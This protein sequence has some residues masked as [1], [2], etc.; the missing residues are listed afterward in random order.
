M[1]IPY[2][3]WSGYEVALD[4]HPVLTK[5]LINVVIY[6]VGDYM[7][8]VQWGQRDMLEFDLSRILKNG[9]IGAMFGPVVHQYYGKCLVA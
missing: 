2:D 6:I 9:L 8:Q 7:A 5:T 4:E 3:N 1:R